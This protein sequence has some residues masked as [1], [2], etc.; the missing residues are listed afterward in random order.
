MRSCDN[1]DRQGRGKPCPYILATGGHKRETDEACLHPANSLEEVLLQEFTDLGVSSVSS[2]SDVSDVSGKFKS[3]WHTVS[4]VSSVSSVSGVSDK[5]KSRRITVSSVSSVSSVSGVSGV[6]NLVGFRD[7][8]YL[9]YHE[10]A[11]VLVSV[12]CIS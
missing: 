8:T 4:S 12:T 10:R 2:V 9:Y 7:C 6:Y 3:R 5:F 1:C 11:T